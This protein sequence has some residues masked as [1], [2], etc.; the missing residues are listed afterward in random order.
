MRGI[1][2]LGGERLISEEGPYL[3][4]LINVLIMNSFR[5]FL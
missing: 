1:P 3:M 5:C 2:L 4:K